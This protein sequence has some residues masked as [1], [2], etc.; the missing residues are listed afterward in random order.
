MWSASPRL[1]AQV[2]FA[3]F[4]MIIN[5]LKEAKEAVEEHKKEDEA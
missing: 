5:T 1:R 3:Q 2:N 4:E